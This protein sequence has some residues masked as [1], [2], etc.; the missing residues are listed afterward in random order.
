MQL[1]HFLKF[2]LVT[3]FRISTNIKM[4]YF[5]TDEIYKKLVQ[6][7]LLKESL[8]EDL[9]IKRVKELKD[10]TKQSQIDQLQNFYNK[11]AQITILDAK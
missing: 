5:T 4:E 8:K 10:M 7:D 1:S 11:V 9:V 3:I 2:F 6:K